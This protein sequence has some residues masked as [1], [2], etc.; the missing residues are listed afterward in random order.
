ML[1]VQGALWGILVILVIFFLTSGALA[2]PVQ[3]DSQ[4]ITV[5]EKINLVDLNKN[6]EKLN[7]NVEELNKNLEKLSE[8]VANLSKNVVDLNTRVAVLEERTKGTAKVQHVI[9]SSIIAPI[10]VAILL[11][12]LIQAFPQ[13]I[14]RNSE[15]S[16]K[17]PR[18]HLSNES[19]L[20][21]KD[22]IL[23]GYQKAKDAA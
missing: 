2:E 12:I 17:S 23:P 15:T 11:Y 19:Q 22:S 13:W 21:L 16:D 4:V 14:N 6:V 18:S 3:P 10:V 20:N 1:N 9:L 7:K 5:T 8:N